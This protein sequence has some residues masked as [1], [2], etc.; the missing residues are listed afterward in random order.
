[1]TYQCL[2]SSTPTLQRVDRIGQKNPVTVYRLIA[3]DAVE[4]RVFALHQE[5]TA[6]AADVLDG[7]ASSALTPAQLM[8][9][10]K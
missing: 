2:D 7:T 9:L 3:S 6:L 5:K 1:M 10:F 8:E 4:E